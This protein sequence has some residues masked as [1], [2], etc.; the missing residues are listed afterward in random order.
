MSA[1]H[2]AVGPS[3]GPHARLR[4]SDE[5]LGRRRAAVRALMDE[6]GVEALLLYGSPGLDSEVSY[7]SD[8]NVTREAVFVLPASGD[9]AL[10]VEYFNHIPNA[11]R[12]ARGCDVRWGRENVTEIVVADLRERGL[13]GAS[14]GFAG[15]LPVQRYLALHEA[16]PSLTLRDL[17][18]DLRRM[19]LVKS[20]EEIALLRRGAWLTDLAAEALAREARPGLTEYD[21][22]AIIEAAYLR[23][24][25]QTTIHYLAT[26]PMDAPDR[27]VPSQ[28]PTERRLAPGDA[29]LTEISAHYRGYPGQ[30]LR[31]FTIGADPTPA[32]Q[33]LFDVAVEAF[34][35][36]AAT[37]KAGATVEDVLDAAEYI[38]AEGFTI[39]DDLLHGYGGGYLPPVLRTRQTSARPP[40]PFTF[41]EN[42]TVVIQPNVITPDG[43][44]GVQVGELVRV[45][46]DGCE[47]LHSYPMRFTRCG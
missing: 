26:T 6:A 40:A 12:R 7:L 24:G 27:C 18:V 19:R 16:L 45:T 28:Q 25:G 30:L 33:Q 9:P 17:S 39:C 23:A 29:L 46:R 5:E 47:R 8:F 34:E 22:V 15:M 31:P 38:H 3:D 35:Q 14:V 4:L 10:Y 44:S 2:A 36:I 1:V 42:M 21:L 43:R 13:A 41:E 20:E 32:Y 11:R 37:L